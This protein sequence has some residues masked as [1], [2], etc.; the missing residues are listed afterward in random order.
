MVSVYRVS[1]VQDAQ[2]L[3]EPCVRPEG[4]DLAEFWRPSSAEYLAKRPRYDAT[5]RIAPAIRERVSGMGR[6]LHAEHLE[7][8]DA[9]GWT[10]VNLEF[11]TEEEAARYVVGYGTL[12]EVLGPQALR[13]RV[14]DLAEGVVT[15]HARQGVRTLVQ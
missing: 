1:R 13:E 9:D 2:V 8:P 10:Q 6:C 3:D 4:F 11:E 15:L 7:P 14:I 5:V 12:M